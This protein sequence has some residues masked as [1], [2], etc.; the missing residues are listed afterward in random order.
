MKLV[1]NDNNWFKFNEQNLLG[2]AVGC[3][4]GVVRT[5]GTAGREDTFL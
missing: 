2:G 3:G 4:V 5:G 1:L